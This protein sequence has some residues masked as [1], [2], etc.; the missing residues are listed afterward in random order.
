MF[1]LEAWLPPHK[2]YGYNSSE[3]LLM[4]LITGITNFAGIPV[5]ILLHK[6]RRH[7]EAFIAFFTM[8]TSFMYHAMESVDAGTVFL[9]EGAW[10]RLDNIG[11][12]AAFITLFV[13]LM[14][15]ENP[16]LDFY[17]TMGGFFSTLR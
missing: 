7:L 17:L 11:S 3:Q 1:N 12:I 9:N 2:K 16:V 14:D 15:N 13:H 6:S 4:L 5:I 10:H 8:S